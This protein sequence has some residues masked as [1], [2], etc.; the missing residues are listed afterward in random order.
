MMPFNK[1]KNTLLKYVFNA[2]FLMVTY[3]F[4]ER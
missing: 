3:K 4:K 2:Y 1:Y